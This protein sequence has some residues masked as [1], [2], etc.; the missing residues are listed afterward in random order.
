MQHYVD[1][2]PRGRHGSHEYSFGELG[3]DAAAERSRFS[4]YTSHFSVPDEVS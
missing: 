2:R 1:A 3:L 4:P